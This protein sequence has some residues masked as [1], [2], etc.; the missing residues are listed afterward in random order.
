[1]PQRNVTYWRK[2][3]SVMAIQN[4]G[5][6]NFVDVIKANLEWENI[7]VDTSMSMETRRGVFS[8]VDQM[9]D[10]HVEL[11]RGVRKPMH[12]KN[13]HY[14]WRT[15]DW[16]VVDAQGPRHFTNDQFKDH[17][18]EVVTETSVTMPCL[19]ELIL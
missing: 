10:V 9:D 14:L 4:D 8:P 18:F 13:D 15:G 16:F 11:R 6:T 1:M 19:E 2:P 5:G 7:T 12:M 17:Y 3:V